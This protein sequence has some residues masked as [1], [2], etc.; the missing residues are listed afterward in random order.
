MVSAPC[1][2]CGPAFIEWLQA[3]PERWA[4]WQTLPRR[5]LQRGQSL[6]SQGQ[7]VE[8]VWCLEQGLVRGFF[9]DPQ[10]RERNHAFYAEHEWLGATRFGSASPWHLQALESSQVVELSEAALQNLQAQ[11][12]QAPSLIMQALQAGLAHQTE[13]EHALL[14]LDAAERY[15]SFLQASPAL[16]QRLSQKHIAS[17]LGITEVAL[18]RIRRRLRERSD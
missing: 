18:S 4:H 14:M 6:Q 1:P 12:P 17:Y 8:R 5:A 13:R 3:C 7:R 16:A 9:L 2:L 15:R 11:W 10:G